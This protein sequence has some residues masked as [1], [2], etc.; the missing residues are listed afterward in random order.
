MK[1]LLQIE[2][3]YVREYTL[4]C[5]FINITNSN[6]TDLVDYFSEYIYT[7]MEDNFMSFKMCSTLREMTTPTVASNIININDNIIINCICWL[8]GKLTTIMNSIRISLII[9]RNLQLECILHCLIHFSDMT[10]LF[11]QWILSKNLQL[12]CILHCLIHFSDMTPCQIKHNVYDA[13]FL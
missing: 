4:T 3:W 5:R 8:N 2:K 7:V 13:K 11:G 12:E 10:P 9:F 6:L 1:T